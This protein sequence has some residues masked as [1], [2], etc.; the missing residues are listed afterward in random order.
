MNVIIKNHYK[1]KLPINIVKRVKRLLK[2]V[3][4]NYL[5]DLKMISIVNRITYSKHRNASGIYL[6]KDKS[7]EARIEIAIDTIYMESNWF[8]MLL[9]VLSKYFLA[10]V[11]YHEIG[12]HYQYE[13]KS[14]KKKY[15][16]DFAEKISNE[17][18]KRYFSNWKYL[19][20][21][22]IPFIWLLKR[23]KNIFK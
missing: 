4:D 8:L 1:G 13:K 22:L 16:E 20:Y 23:I 15:R 2:Y 11:L 19:L 6:P 7:S 10:R 14:L 12:H 18:L 3:P 21:P 5:F 17:L 9:P